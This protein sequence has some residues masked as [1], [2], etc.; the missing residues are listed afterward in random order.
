LRSP[1]SYLLELIAQTQTNEDLKK[2]EL[3]WVNRIPLPRPV[4]KFETKHNFVEWSLEPNAKRRSRSPA[5][6]F[7]GFLCWQQDL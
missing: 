3:L 1:E 2:D 4:G 5:Q 6:I 7:E